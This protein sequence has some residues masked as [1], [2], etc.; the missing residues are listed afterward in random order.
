[1][2]MGCVEVTFSRVSTGCVDVNFT[3]IGGNMSA[4]LGLVCEP[5]LP[6]LRVNDGGFVLVSDNGHLILNEPFNYEYDDG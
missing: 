6:F 5:S 4:S 3:R 2:C 1:M